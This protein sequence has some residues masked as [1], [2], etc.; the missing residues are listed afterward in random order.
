[1]FYDAIMTALLH[2]ILSSAVQILSHSSNRMTINTGR[3]FYITPTVIH[4]TTL[5]G[6]PATETYGRNGCIVRCK[7]CLYATRVIPGQ[8]DFENNGCV[9]IEHIKIL[10]TSPNIITRFQTSNEWTSHLVHGMLQNCSYECLHF[11]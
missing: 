4:G 7:M 6:I 3:H 10:F 2:C 5:K 9:S 8:K 1:M 11:C